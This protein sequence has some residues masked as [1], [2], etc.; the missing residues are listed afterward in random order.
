MLWAVPDSVL[1]RRRHVWWQS[2]EDFCAARTGPGD[3][4]TASALLPLAKGLPYPGAVP[5][6]KLSE[7]F[8]CLYGGSIPFCVVVIGI[9]QFVLSLLL[10]FLFLLAVRNHFR[11][12]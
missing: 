3:P 7:V 5:A 12:R 1:N 2:I 11:I 4:W 8:C 10:L 6:E 9:F